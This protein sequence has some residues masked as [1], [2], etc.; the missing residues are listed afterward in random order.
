MQGEKYVKGK[1]KIQWQ[2]QNYSYR[3]RVKR[4]C[5]NKILD[6]I[7]NATFREQKNPQKNPCGNEKKNDSRNENRSPGKSMTKLF[8][9]PALKTVIS[10]RVPDSF[11]GEKYLETWIWM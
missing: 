5:S 11:I 3:F 2:Q 9:A 8:P 6:S 4:H 10:P 1:S 7:K